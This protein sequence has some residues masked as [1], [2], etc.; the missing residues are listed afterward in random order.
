MTPNKIRSIRK[1]LGMSA[2]EFAHAIGYYGKNAGASVWRLETGKR[3]PSGATVM[4][5]EMLEG[6][7]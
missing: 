7:K 2:T 3:N 6:E 1:L 4:L 5:I